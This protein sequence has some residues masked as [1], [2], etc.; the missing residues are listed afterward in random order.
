VADNVRRLPRSRRW[1]LLAN[2]WVLVGAVVVL[3][4]AAAVWAI[5]FSRLL[6]AQTL[7]VSGNVRTETSVISR[8]ARLAP[9]VPLARTDID[10][11]AAR[12]AALP[13]IESVSVRRSWP[14]TVAVSVVERTAVARL[15]TADGIRAI[16]AAGAVFRPA[17]TPVGSLP[18]LTTSANTTPD[19]IVEGAAVAAQLPPRITDRLDAIEVATKDSIT[20]RLGNGDAVVWGSAQD[21]KRKARVLMAL[22][23]RPATVYDVSVPGLPTTTGG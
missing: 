3:V 17:G 12:V 5:F 7:N 4:T 18:L 1:H 23:R 20:L 14:H 11:I 21:A 8:A 13:A 19:A 10:A 16:D 6:I 22:L 2:R 9:G 15:D